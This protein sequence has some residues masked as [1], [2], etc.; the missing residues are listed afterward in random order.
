MSDRMLVATRKGLHHARERNGELDG[1]A[2]RLRRHSGHRS[3]G[4]RTRRHDL[5]SAQAR[6]FR[7]QT[8]SLR[9]R[10]ENM[11]G[12]AGAGL[13]AP[14]R[15]VRRRCSSYGRLKLAAPAEKAAFG[16]ARSRPGCFAPTIEARTG[17]SVSALWNVPEREKWFGG[18]YDDAGIH[19]ISPDPR[20]AD[21]IFVAISCGGV[22]E[23]AMPAR[24]GLLHGEGLVAAY[25]PPDRR[26]QQKCRTRIASRAAMRR[27]M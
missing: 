21:R 18:G 3:A 17:S 23:R 4:R 15:P 24:V 2:H 25:M 19:S 8:T 20:D 1:R 7:H 5:R 14:M 12:T 22:W 27:R 10:R 9:R 13:S 16:P 6:P 26:A 11:D